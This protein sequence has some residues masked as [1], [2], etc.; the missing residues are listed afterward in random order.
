MEHVIGSCLDFCP[1]PIW[2][3]LYP[4]RF[5]IFWRLLQTINIYSGDEK[6]R[7]TLQYVMIMADWDLVLKKNVVVF[8]CLRCFSW[9][10]K[11]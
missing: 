9:N 6:I 4:I 10:P 1:A 7:E 2:Y 3:H 11:M 8:K 5:L